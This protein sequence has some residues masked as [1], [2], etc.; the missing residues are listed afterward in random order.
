MGSFVDVRGL[1]CADAVVK[2][3]RAME[4]A[5]KGGTVTV[6][7]NDPVALI[8]FKAYADKK[9]HKWGAR[10]ALEGGVTEVE[11]TRVA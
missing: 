2:V 6:R 4:A 8:D 3:H 5:P 10:R 1:A 11:I 9:G 7:T